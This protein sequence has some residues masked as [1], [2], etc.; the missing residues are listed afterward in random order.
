LKQNK[1]Y[2]QRGV[3]HVTTFAAWIDGDY[4]KRFGEPPLDRFGAGLLRTPR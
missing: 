4:V 2:A 3:R 1:T